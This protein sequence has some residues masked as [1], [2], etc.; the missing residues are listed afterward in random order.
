M[1]Q[2]A[3][4]GQT[5]GTRARE[6][7]EHTSP[8]RAARPP[9]GAGGRRGATAP[10]GAPPS[11]AVAA[12][13]RQ[14]RR[15]HCLLRLAAGAEEEEEEE[16]AAA[17]ERRKVVEK[18]QRRRVLFVV[19]CAARAQ[20]TGTVQQDRGVLCRG[21]CLSSFPPAGEEEKEEEEEEGAAQTSCF[22]FSWFSSTAGTIDGG[23]LFPQ[24]CLC[25]C[26]SISSLVASICWGGLRRLV[27]LEYDLESTAASGSWWTQAVVTPTFFPVHVALAGVSPLQ[28]HF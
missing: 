21:S 4:R 7:T 20:D 6:E 11:G 23:G 10:C 26:A 9:P 8:G 27:M 16:A 28:T 18:E 17:E 24:A 14:R 2:N 12:R 19:V 1:Q 22:L 3:L 5:T 25:L 15:H 13:R